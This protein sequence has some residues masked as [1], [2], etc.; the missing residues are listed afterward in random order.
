MKKLNITIYMLLLMLVSTSLDAQK[1]QSYVLKDKPFYVLEEGGPVTV[2]ELTNNGSTMD[3][4]GKDFANSLYNTI[5]WNKRGISRNGK[6]KVFNPWYTTNIYELTKDESAA[7]Y[8]IGGNYIFSGNVIKSHELLK[9][10]D[11]SKEAI[12]FFYYKHSVDATAKVDG[13]ITITSTSK[14][15]L[16]KE[17]SLNNEK[18]KTDYKFVE[19]PV[20]PTIE[21]YSKMLSNEVINRSRGMFS[22]I[23]APKTYS[24]KAVKG[25]KVD[26]VFK[27]EMKNKKKVFKALADAGSVNELGKAYIVLVPDE[28]KIKKPQNLYYN[29]G[30]CYE[31]IGNFTK[32][33]ENYL[34][35]ADKQAITE[36]D[37]LIEMKDLFQKLGLNVV[38]NDF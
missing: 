33:K 18:T 4:F 37:K 28:A 11:K 2:Q 13:K 21:K 1:I 25:D 17:F 10:K 20:T 9:S 31:L 32:A 34:K 8:V 22:P 27:K 24:F 15:E 19:Y 26:K 36:I 23:Y 16:V 14:G 35:S 12:P 5:N 6:G 29:I 38:E 3:A 7:K 30:L